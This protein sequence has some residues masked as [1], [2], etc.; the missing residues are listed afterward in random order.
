MIP[1]QEE[2]FAKVKKSKDFGVLHEQRLDHPQTSF[3]KSDIYGDENTFLTSYNLL[4]S[5]KKAFHYLGDIALE[6]IEIEFNKKK[7]LFT[8]PR[9]VK[10]SKNVLRQYNCLDYGCAKC[11]KKPKFWNIFSIDQYE[12]NVSK[13]T[14]EVYNGEFTTAIVNGIEHKFYVESHTDTFCNHLDF[15]GEFCRIHEL[16]PIHC[17]LPL[18]KFKR[19][20]GITYVTKEYFG[21]NWNMRCPAVFKPLDEDGFNG[22]IYMMNRVKKFADEMQVK[23]HIDKIIDDIT[24]MYG[25]TTLKSELPL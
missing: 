11:C 24:S 17:A 25:E 16:N 3:I 21:R 7:I 14:S 5:F 23:T 10:V 20:K 15:E 13:Y 19:M 9:G 18:T 4:N 12:E 1:S 6:P 2:I 8:P 22:L